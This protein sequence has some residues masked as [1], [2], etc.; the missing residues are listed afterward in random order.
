MALRI[1]QING[2]EKEIGKRLLPNSI[3]RNSQVITVIGRKIEVARIYD[4]HPEQ[5]GEFYALFKQFQVESKIG[6]SDVRNIGEHGVALVSPETREWVSI[7]ETINAVFGYVGPIVIFK[8]HQP[9]TSW[10]PENTK[11]REY[12][13]SENGWTTNQIATT[14]LLTLY[15]ES[16]ILPA[17][18]L[19]KH[20]RIRQALRIRS[21]DK[22]YPLRKRALE[23]VHTCLIHLANLLPGLHDSEILFLLQDN[24]SSQERICSLIH[25]T[26]QYT[27]GSCQSLDS[28]RGGYIAYHGGQKITSGNSRLNNFSAAVNAEITAIAASIEAINR[29]YPTH[30]A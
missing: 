3:K 26:H 30:L 16:G 20:A 24:P 4:T 29:S 22:S 12:I 18:E 9:R 19:L 21:L 11:S 6:L 28:T 8:S 25:D 13:T 14:P 15:R 2:D 23:Q 5:I 10:S 1:I 17:I 7:I 27:D